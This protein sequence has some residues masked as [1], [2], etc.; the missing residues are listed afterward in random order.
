MKVTV[1][2]PLLPA[3]GEDPRRATNPV[4]LAVLVAPL[5]DSVD[6]ERRLFASARHSA[7]A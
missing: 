3:A 6:A 1:A 5:D 4:Q 2:E 7:Q